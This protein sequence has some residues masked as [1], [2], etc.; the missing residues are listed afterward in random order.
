MLLSRCLG[1]GVI[2]AAAMRGRCDPWHLDTCLKQLSTSQHLRLHELLTL[3]KKEPGSIHACTDITGFGLL[4]H[5][6]EMLA[7]SPSIAIDLR[8]NAIPSFD[9]ALN[10]LNS[11]LASTLAPS[12]R[13]ALANLGSRVRTFEGSNDVSNSLNPGIEALL[14]DPQTCGP[15]LVSCS[16]AIARLLEDKGWIAIGEA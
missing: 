7:A 15:L 5:L 14:V 11:G 9:G 10:L 8:I 4:G 3:Q 13:R 6:N 16:S 2:F 12:N 1:S